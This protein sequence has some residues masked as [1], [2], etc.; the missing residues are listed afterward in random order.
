M[1]ERSYLPSVLAE[2]NACGVPK[3]GVFMVS[4]ICYFWSPSGSRV[5]VVIGVRQGRS[6]LELGPASGWVRALAAATLAPDPDPCL[7]WCC[8]CG[9]F[10]CFCCFCCC[11][12]GC[13]GTQCESN[14]DPGLFILVCGGGGAVG[15][16]ALYASDR[17]AEYP[18]LLWT[19]D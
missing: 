2:R 7:R 12:C 1:A 10:C 18:I 13:V 19:G 5:G 16:P 8:C 17:D 6:R 3:Y 15:D 9:C 14:R 4:M 11:G